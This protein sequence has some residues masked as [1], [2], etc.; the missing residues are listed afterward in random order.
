[1][2]SARHRFAVQ[3]HGSRG[4]LRGPD[5]GAR[6][7]RLACSGRRDSL[8]PF[9]LP[10]PPPR[11]VRRGPRA[12]RSDD[13]DACAS[14]VG[15]LDAQRKRGRSW[16]GDPA[17][18]FEQRR[19][20]VALSRRENAPLFGSRGGRP[21]AD[22][23][24]RRPSMLDVAHGSRAAGACRRGPPAPRSAPCRHARKRRGPSRRTGGIT[25]SR[26][27]LDRFFFFG[28]SRS[29][30]CPW[31][32]GRRARGGSHAEAGRSASDVGGDRRPSHGAA[33]PPPAATHSALTSRAVRACSGATCAPRSR[34]PRARTARSSARGSRRRGPG[35]RTR[36]AGRGG[37]PPAA[38]R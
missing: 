19:C 9:E 2:A 15:S 32:G 36:P 22:T 37:R 34:A 24:R 27:S 11:S 26:A 35:R 6:G 14:N 38:R 30:R 4:E 18:P 7:P 17:G 20:D 13:R 1:M 3:G 12:P 21:A 23:P 5:R 10:W 29:P 33:R 16:A 31:S 25:E 8:D 28:A